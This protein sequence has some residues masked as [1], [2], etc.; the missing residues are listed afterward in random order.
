Y[1]EASLIKVIGILVLDA[2]FSFD[3]AHKL[4]LVPNYLR[5]LTQSS[6]IVVLA[7]KF[8]FKL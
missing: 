2:I 1:L 4:E 6:L 5:I 3:V 8:N 7:I